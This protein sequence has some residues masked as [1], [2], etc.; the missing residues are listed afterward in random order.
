VSACEPH[1]TDAALVVGA[2]GWHPGV[3]GIIA[4]K[5]V[6]KYARPAIVIGFEAG[7]GRGSAR[8]VPGFNLYDA[9][10]A[11]AAHLSRY[12]GHAAAAGMTLELDRLDAFRHAFVREAALRLGH[13]TRPPLVVDAVVELHELDL[14]AAEELGRLAPFGAAN[15][16][17]I[18]A[19]PGVTT[20]S[21]R[22]VGQG[23]LMLTL[24]H[25]GATGDAIAF[26]MADRDPGQGACVDL[27][28]S[29]ELDTFRGNR[30]A[31]LKVKHLYRRH[32]S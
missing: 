30:R 3:V 6:E 19:L 29:A 31:R 26:G 18:F 23:H 21:T 24:R 28:A 17:P 9:L 15:A 20:E 11:C 1:E 27:V 22:L 4:A 14:N 12:G 7:Q 5:L 2:E 32:D 8:T 10:A 16:Q 25:R 13:A